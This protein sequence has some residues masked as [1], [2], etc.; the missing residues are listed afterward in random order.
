MGFNPTFYASRPKLSEVTI[1]SDLNM[2]GRNILKV[3]RIESPYMPETWET[4]TLEWGDVL[5]QTVVLTVES[6]ISVGSP[7]SQLEVLTWETPD[8]PRR[9]EVYLKIGGSSYGQM[10]LSFVS[11]GTTIHSLVV[12]AIQTYTIPLI[13]PPSATISMLADN[14]SGY[15]Q[16]VDAGSY[17]KKTG[18]YAGAKTFDLTGKWLALGL[19]MK[20]LDATVKIQGVEIPYSDYAKYFPLAPTELKIPGDWDQTQERPVIKVYK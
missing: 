12:S 6:N 8:I 5:E 17:I 19:D 18:I 15:T 1:D 16:R 20:G 7:S 4:E 9:W 13:L 14:T 10:T 11:G 2:G 3:G